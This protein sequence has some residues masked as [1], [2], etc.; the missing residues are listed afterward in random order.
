VNKN[1]EKA[2]IALKVGD[3]KGWTAAEALWK[4]NRTDGVG[5]TEISAQLTDQLGAGYSQKTVSR[6]IAVWER[7]GQS[8]RTKS[9]TEA[10]YEMRE[11]GGGRE[12]IANREARK[13]VRERPEVIA[14][15]LRVAPGDGAAIVAN[16]II[17]S[18]P[19]KVA[20]AITEAP[21]EVQAKIADA[22]VKAPA[23]EPV[24]RNIAKRSSEPAPQAP[25]P[26]A[27]RK[28]SDGVF[29]LWEAGEL[30]MDE[31]PGGEERVRMIAMAEKAQRLAAG[32]LHL[33]DSGELEAEFSKL[34]EE[35]G[36]EA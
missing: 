35:V 27:E 9:F 30:L 14:E 17:N 28:L 4:A 1:V 19:E 8:A 12:G 21:R 6:Y 11:T 23:T 32:I 26:R 20:Q 2:A 24:L 34:I 31:T 15:E 13:V 36:A 25:S 18:S 10:Y 29:R 5:Q 33:I 16:S 3:E 7:D 22:L